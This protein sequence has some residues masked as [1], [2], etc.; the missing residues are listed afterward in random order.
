[1]ASEASQNDARSSRSSSS[2]W[3]KLHLR[4]TLLVSLVLLLSVGVGVA[5]GSWRNLCT[6]CPSIAQ[7]FTWEP[8]QTS[9]LFDRQGDLISEIGYERRTQ[10]LIN[11]M[12]EYVS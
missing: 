8:E 2:L 3:E 11:A 5:W 4:R 12:R 10:V 1:M 6:D 9:K 7:I